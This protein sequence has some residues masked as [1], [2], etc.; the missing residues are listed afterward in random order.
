MTRR[1]AAFARRVEADPFFLASALS[2]YAHSEE[3]DEQGLA[4][5]LGCSLDTLSQLRLCR[6]PHPDPASFRADIDR[7]AARFAVR[8]TVLAE[9]VRRA[10]AL[11][12]LRHTATDGRGLLMAARDRGAEE[13]PSTTGEGEA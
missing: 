5:A 11:A 4:L 12:G 7:I 6:R 13:P 8:A 2:D 9:A 10:D 1:I 3:L